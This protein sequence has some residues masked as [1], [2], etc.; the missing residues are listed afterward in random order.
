M[1]SLSFITVTPASWVSFREMTLI[2]VLAVNPVRPE[3]PPT[4]MIHQTYSF[5]DSVGKPNMGSTDLNCLLY[6]EMC[7][8]EKELPKTKLLENQGNYVT[9]SNGSKQILGSLCL[10]SKILFEEYLLK[11]F[12]PIVKEAELSIQK[13]KVNGAKSFEFAYAFGQNPNH[14]KYEDDYFLMKRQTGSDGIYEDWFGVNKGGDGMQNLNGWRWVNEYSEPKDEQKF[15]GIQST[16]QLT[17]NVFRL[18]LVGQLIIF[19]K[20]VRYAI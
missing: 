19:I 11:F 12:R 13:V 14:S 8:K 5:A 18:N 7:N 10:S 9:S 15:G 17:G 6:L 2:D 1:V 20:H 3:L 4:V 16:F